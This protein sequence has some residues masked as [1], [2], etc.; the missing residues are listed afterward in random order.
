MPNASYRIADLGDKPAPRSWRLMLGADLMAELS[1]L[2]YETPWITV[3]VDPRPGLRAYLPYFG[4]PDAWADD[5]PAIDAMLAAIRA[6]GGFRL[7]DEH[8]GEA[9]PFTLVNLDERFGNLRY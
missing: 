4:D 1:F 9:A 3:S 6:A 7:W 5:D 2:E 8:G